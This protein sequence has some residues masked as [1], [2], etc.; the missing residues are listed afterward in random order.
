MKQQIRNIV[1]FGDSYSTFAGYV[2]EGYAVYYS[3]E[4]KPETDVRR[5]EETWWHALCTKRGWNLVQNNSWSGSTLCYS[6]YD[7]DCSETSSFICRMERL[8]KEGFFEKNGIDTVFVFGCTNDSWSNAPLG[9]IKLSDHT[10]DDLFSVCPAVGYFVGR[11]R[12]LLPNGNVIFVMNTALKPEIDEAIKAACEHNDASYIE[13]V[14]INKECGHPTVLG[15]SQIREQ[16]EA[17]LDA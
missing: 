10:R 15:M 1:I 8:A 7:G 11:L 14:R 5:V 2:P 3:T 16:I 17:F 13:L 9:E 4:E 12:E 6:G